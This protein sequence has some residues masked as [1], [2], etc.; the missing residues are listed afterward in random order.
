MRSEQFFT[1]C[2]HVMNLMCFRENVDPASDQQEYEEEIQ[3]EVMELEA[4]KEEDYQRSLAEYR[5][6][7]EEWKLWRKKQV[8]S[9]KQTLFFKQWRSLF[10]Y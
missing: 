1:F 5:K 10:S 4:E 2:I 9:Q 6:Q 3:A 7:L 8:L